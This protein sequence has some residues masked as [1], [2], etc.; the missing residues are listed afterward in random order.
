MIIAVAKRKLKFYTGGGR[1]FVS[2]KDVSSAIVNSLEI[3]N[4]GKY[5]IT[6]NENISY[7]TFFKKIATVV[8]QPAPQIKIPNWS[9]KILG[10]MGNLFGYLLKK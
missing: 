6:G 4:I 9:I 5:Y 7:R 8:E 10:Y 2:V 3:Q 1:N